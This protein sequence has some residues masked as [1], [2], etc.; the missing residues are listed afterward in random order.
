MLGRKADISRC[1]GNCHIFPTVSATDEKDE[2]STSYLEDLMVGDDYKIFIDGNIVGG[3][4]IFDL[5]DTDFHVTGS[6]KDSSITLYSNMRMRRRIITVP[7]D[8]DYRYKGDISGTTI[9]HGRGNLIQVQS[10]HGPYLIS[11]VYV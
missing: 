2:K 3:S 11:S 1:F 10:S 8:E 4:T 5:C 9:I 6:V 7:C